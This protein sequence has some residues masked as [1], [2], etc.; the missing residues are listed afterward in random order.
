MVSFLLM[1]CLLLHA[2]H[3]RC[4]EVL[5]S[6]APRHCF[7]EQRKRP[8]PLFYARVS[9]KQRRGFPLFQP[10]Y[11]C[12]PGALQW[13][14]HCTC[15]LRIWDHQRSS[16]EDGGIGMAKCRWC[17]QVE[18]ALDSPCGSFAPFSA[19]AAIG[20]SK[21]HFRSRWIRMRQWLI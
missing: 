2:G 20:I 19:A 7:S 14:Q 8:N 4:R 5:R 11:E 9:N 17:P 10:Q 15:V 1:R 16:G 6:S 13:W 18:P 21:M 3:N 12:Q